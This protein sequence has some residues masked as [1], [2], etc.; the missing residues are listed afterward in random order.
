MRGAINEQSNTVI[1]NG[2]RV[3]DEKQAEDGD[4]EQPRRRRHAASP[5]AGRST[6]KPGETENHRKKKKVYIFR[7]VRDGG[8]PLEASGRKALLADPFAAHGQ[9]APR[10]CLWPRG[11]RRRS[12]CTV[13]ALNGH[14]KQWW[15]AWARLLL[16]LVPY[17]DKETTKPTTP[18]Y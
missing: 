6:P 9:R 15:W 17:E 4:P 5:H 13:L 3:P 8:G 7:R 14:A 16:L 2:L 1:W 11:G 18:R 12:I 10:A